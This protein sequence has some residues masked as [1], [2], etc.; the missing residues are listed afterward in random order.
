MLS[1][2]PVNNRFADL[3]NQLA[4][5]YEGD[6]S[7]LS[8]KLSSG[9]S[10]EEIFRQAQRAFNEWQELPAPERT[11][12]EILD[13]LD[14]AFFELLDSGTIARSRKHI[15][16]RYDMAEI[17]SFPQRLKPQSYRC[18]LTARD[19]VPDFNAIYDELSKLILA[20]YAPITYVHDSR[21]GQYGAQYDTE[22]A[23]NR[24][25]QEDR[26]LSIRALMRVNLLKRLE[27]SV[28]SPRW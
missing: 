7:A 23:T 20:V 25:R 9:Q 15:T 18:V 12:A 24:L 17:G 8:D 3:R 10:V 6:S 5:A 14:F 22:T 26:E 4:L 28:E 13:R 1:A 19:D 27:S 21:K 16:T 2:T 11:P